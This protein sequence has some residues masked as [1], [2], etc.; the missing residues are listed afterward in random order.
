MPN[1]GLK[2]YNA[3]GELRVDVA[4]S[5]GRLIFKYDYLVYNKDY[6]FS[7]LGGEDNEA[8]YQIAVPEMSLWN[9]DEGGVGSIYPRG[10]IDGVPEDYGGAGFTGR[11]GHL[12]GLTGTGYNRTIHANAGYY[13]VSASGGNEADSRMDSVLLLFITGF[14]GSR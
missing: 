2:T 3:A 5:I 9:P 12:W 11:T 14:T 6:S 13:R 10:S 4:D 1:Y 8:G 7:I